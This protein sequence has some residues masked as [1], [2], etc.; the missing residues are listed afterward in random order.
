MG[1]DLLAALKKTLG[2]SSTIHRRPSD[3]TKLPDIG[4]IET[5]I[6]VAKAKEIVGEFY[7]NLGYDLYH[8]GKLTYAINGKDGFIIETTRNGNSTLVDI[9]RD[10]LFNFSL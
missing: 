2:D 7:S 10:Q 1:N 9:S 4:T 5:R 6:P 3:R 8:F